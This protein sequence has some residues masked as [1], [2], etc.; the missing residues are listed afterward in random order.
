MP[1]F[2]RLLAL[3]FLAF[4]LAADDLTV[5]WIS[6]SPEID[7]VWGSTN[8][9][10][11][12]W[13]AEGEAVT[14][15]AHVRNWSG[16][17][18]RVGYRWTID[19]RE[20]AGGEVTLAA[21]A[22]T[23][24]DLPAS[25][26]FERSRIAFEI[27]TANSVTEESE[28]NN[29]LS[30][31]SDALAVGFWVEQSFYDYFRANQW[32]LGVGSTSFEDWAQR[33]IAFYNDMAALAVYPETPEG[34]HD[35]WRL[36]KVVVVPDGALP[37]SGIPA[38][39]L[40]DSTGGSH[41]DK[42]DRTVDLMWGFRTV[43]L[44]TYSGKTA[45][46]PTNIFYV[47]YAI[48]HEL[49]HAR[50]LADVYGWNVY[51]APP[52]YLI[53]IREEGQPIT[54]TFIPEK[55]HRTSQQGLMNEHYTFLD[56]FSAAA[57]NLIAGHR[58]TVGNYNSPLNF[59]S[60]VN[61]LPAQNRL[62]I[63]DAN[64]API[65]HADVWIYDSIADGPNWYATHYDDEP[66]LKLRTDANG[67]V[68]VGRSPFAPDGKIVHT[69]GMMNGVAIVRVATAEKVAYGFL[70][71]IPFNLAYWRGE[72]AFADHELFVGLTCDAR[73]PSLVA[74]AWDSETRGAV[75]LEWNAL[76][77]ATA[78]RV[79]ASTNLGKPQLVAT[80]TGTSAEVTLAGRIHWWVEADLGLCGTRRS[81]TGRLTAQM[82][83]RRRAAR[84]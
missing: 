39:A 53:R 12:G 44:P 64:G 67:Q 19:G 7:Y 14:W 56:R 34:V 42:D 3:L 20:V 36:Q 26:S 16:A 68:L 9:A 78:Y 41:P 38:D 6:R 58:A 75:R 11:E 23:I 29:Q 37:L 25:W 15:R 35:R 72:T 8:P 28:K 80:T 45:P 46:V 17:A 22:V 51:D 4:P 5:G 66:D 1:R 50:Y 77:G 21:D 73:G 32:R 69:Y 71:S 40:P 27:D 65:P 83:P 33:T 43:T 81:A 62:T 47:G 79:Y 84:H 70:E 57:L 63:R 74:P 59:A 31:F 60:F 24:V 10:V 48:V 54:G 61:D 82:A 49:G 76:D 55:G 18:P 52:S 13:P 30:V 2:R